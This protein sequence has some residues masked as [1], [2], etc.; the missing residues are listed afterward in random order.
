M[1][2]GG[3]GLGANDTPREATGRQ[4]NR[5]LGTGPP[6]PNSPDWSTEGGFFGTTANIL[7]TAAGIVGT[8]LGGPVGIGLRAA[9]ALHGA[10]SLAKKFSKGR[11]E[12]SS[13]LPLT[14]SARQL[15]KIAATVAAIEPLR[16][17]YEEQGKKGN[18]G[19]AVAKKRVLGV[20]QKL[21]E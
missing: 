8:V 11:R 6:D 14:S 10:A 2:F 13:A 1:S 20:S 21:G 16:G 9:S 7:G 15:Q 18:K 4:V 19:D 17:A 5:A 3:A 12:A